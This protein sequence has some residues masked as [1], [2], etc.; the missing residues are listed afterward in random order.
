MAL[1]LKLMPLCAQKTVDSADIVREAIL[2]QL[3]GQQMSDLKP[4]L[5]C[6]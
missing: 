2:Q 4:V 5:C 3:Y 1:S 6:M